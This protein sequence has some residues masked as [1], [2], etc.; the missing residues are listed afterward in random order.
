MQPADVI[1]ISMEGA[2][3]KPQIGRSLR[4]FYGC[5]NVRNYLESLA[6]VSHFESVILA[7]SIGSQL[8]NFYNTSDLVCFCNRFTRALPNKIL[9]NGQ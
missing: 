2:I 5:S 8:Y 1:S 3:R 4:Q 7:E 6:E 9:D